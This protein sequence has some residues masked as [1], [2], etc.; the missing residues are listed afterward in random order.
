MA[1]MLF[2]LLEVASVEKA[3]DMWTWASHSLI[4]RL[5]HAPEIVM[6]T[7]AS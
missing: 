3:H 4:D 2:N 7:A 1:Q 6:P 5:C